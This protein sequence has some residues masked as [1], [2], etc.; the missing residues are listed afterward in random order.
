VKIS[1]ALVSASA[2]WVGKM[3]KELVAASS[4]LGKTARLGVPGR[5][6]EISRRHV[7]RERAPLGGLRIGWVKLRA[8]VAG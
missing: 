6:G 7:P 3:G 8:G 5:A 4:G 1:K 2:G